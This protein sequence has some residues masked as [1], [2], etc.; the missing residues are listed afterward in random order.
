MVVFY[1]VDSAIFYAVISKQVDLRSILVVIRQVVNLQEE[2][3]MSQHATL[4]DTGVDRR[5]QRRNAIDGY[6]LSAAA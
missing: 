3:K 2:Q 1:R 5:R 4:G 6:A